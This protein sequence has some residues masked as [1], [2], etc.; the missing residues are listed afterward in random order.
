[1]LYRVIYLLIFVMIMLGLF[2]MRFQ[3]DL[4]VRHVD[5]DALKNEALR[6]VAWTGMPKPSAVLEKEG[7]ISLLFSPYGSFSK[8]QWLKKALK[9]IHLS[10][11]TGQDLIFTVYLN[12]ND[13][14]LVKQ[15]ISNMGDNKMDF[16]L[17]PSTLTL[18]VID[19]GS[20]GS[21]CVAYF[22]VQPQLPNFSFLQSELTGHP[23]DTQ[24]LR[25]KT[26]IQAKSRLLASIANNIVIESSSKA[27]VLIQHHEPSATRPSLE[28]C[29]K[30]ALESSDEYYAYLFFPMLSSNLRDYRLHYN[31]DNQ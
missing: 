18:R 1:M 2:L 5:G 30:A 24:E 27:Y 20:Q 6:L 31:L 3:V 4:R 23:N 13:L 8:K 26:I 9:R 25:V 14:A 21:E 12:E 16:Q 28:V 7:E 11:R 15:L 29:Q 17:L 10:G 19:N 22:D